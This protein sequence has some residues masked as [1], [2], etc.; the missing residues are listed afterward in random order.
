MAWDSGPCGPAGAATPHAL[1]GKSTP[2]LA[3]PYRA[4]GQ[5]GH[6]GSPAPQSQPETV[7][8][9]ARSLPTTV[10]CA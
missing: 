6:L 10:S 2:P 4:T 8:G 1:P 3:G 5:M 9:P 7:M